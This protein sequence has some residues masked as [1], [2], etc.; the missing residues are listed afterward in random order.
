MRTLGL[1][2]GEVDALVAAAKR[3]SD[4]LGDQRIAFQTNC[5]R[6]TPPSKRPAPAPKVRDSPSWGR[7]P[8]LAEDTPL[9]RDIA[10]WSRVSG[11]RSS[12]SAGAAECSRHGSGRC[13][14]RTGGALFDATHQ[15]LTSLLQ[16][17]QGI[18]IAPTGSRP[19]PAHRSRGRAERRRR[20]LSW[21]GPK[22]PPRTST[23]NSS[24]RASFVPMPSPRDA[25]RAAE[26]PSHSPAGSIGIT[27]CRFR[28]CPQDQSEAEDTTAPPPP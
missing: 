24:P 22:E 2:R 20:A 4:Q 18:R 7:S 13:E 12:G 16:A 8:E 25:W 9:A 17:A 6:S 27:R 3:S 14:G 15:R 1:V 28:S 5:S 26:P 19:R 23:T 10:A 11:R 21:H